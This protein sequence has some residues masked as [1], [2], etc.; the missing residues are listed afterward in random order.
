MRGTSKEISRLGADE[1]P[2]NHSDHLT[3]VVPAFLR[4]RRPSKETS[5]L[6]VGPLYHTDHH[7][8]VVPAILRMRR[9]SKE[10]FRLGAE[11]LYHSDHHAV[12]VPAFL[13]P[14][15]EFHCCLEI[16]ENIWHRLGCIDILRLYWNPNEYKVSAIVS[17]IL[18]ALFRMESFS[19]LVRLLACSSR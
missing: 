7:S 13:R 18:T 8:V 3:V 6:G 9:T 5:W 11:P 1:S 4:T 19:L 17:I 12:V 16:R 14:P 15:R 2:R 10:I